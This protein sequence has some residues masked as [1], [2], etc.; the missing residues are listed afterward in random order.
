MDRELK[1]RGRIRQRSKK[2]QR[3]QPQ[4]RKLVAEVLEERPF[5]EF[6]EPRH[7]SQVVHEVVMRSHGGSIT[8]PDNCK[9]LCHFH[10]RWVHDHPAESQELGW[11]K[12]RF[13]V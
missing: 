1:V 4:R 9:A 6:A 12:R 8:D 11:L 5:C 2:L 3:L 7:P 13:G 10:H